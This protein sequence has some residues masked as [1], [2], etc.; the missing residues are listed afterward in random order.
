MDDLTSIKKKIYVNKKTYQVRISS[1]LLLKENEKKN[2]NSAAPNIIH[3][4]DS[5]V[6]INTINDLKSMG[7]GALCI[8][9]AIGVPIKYVT[10]V[11]K[12]YKINLIKTVRKN[13]K[14]GFFPYQKNID[15]GGLNIEH[16]IFNSDTLFC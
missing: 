12:V 10:L 11:N 8:H 3:S 13:I 14:S 4:Y 7:V 16:E 2:I 6:L 9:D 5:Y 1:P 15:F